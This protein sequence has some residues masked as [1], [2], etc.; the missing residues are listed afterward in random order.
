MKKL[1]RFARGY[2]KN[3]ALVI[4]LLAVQA[5]CDLSLPN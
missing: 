1:V 5:F 2:G 3:I 4:L